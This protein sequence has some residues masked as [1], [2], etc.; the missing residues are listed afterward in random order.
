MITEATGALTT[1]EET[2]R[3]TLA[4]CEAWR[5]LT[6]TVGNER[7]SLARIHTD[8]LPPPPDEAEA[9]NREQVEGLRPYA[10]LWLAA[11]GGFRRHIVAKDTRNRFSDS[12]EV[13]VKICA[14]V[15]S[16]LAGDPAEADRQF[17]NSIGTII[18]QLCDLA[19]QAGYLDFTEL[20][21][22]AGPW[23]NGDEEALAEG[24]VIGC[25]MSLL[26]DRQ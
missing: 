10:L 7:S 1:V 20:E 25:D 13:R 26:W 14:T 17:K 24:D 4:D 22:T 12:G 6:A 19:G 9:Y 18:N 5:E 16:E 15:P 2:A 8:A 21:L 23:R 3:H 11:D